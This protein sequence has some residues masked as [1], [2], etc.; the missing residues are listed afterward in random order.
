MKG[1]R[2]REKGIHCDKGH[3]R[4]AIPPSSFLPIFFFLSFS[5][6]LR[7]CGIAAVRRCRFVDFGPYALHLRHGIL[8]RTHTCST[9]R[10]FSRGSRNAAHDFAIIE[11]LNE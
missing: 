8:S 6:Y 9:S 1:K 10:H 11:F 5:S 3:S 4:G 7:D 2:E